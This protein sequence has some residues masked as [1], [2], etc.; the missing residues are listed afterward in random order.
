MDAELKTQLESLLEELSYIC[1]NDFVAHEA[2][3]SIREGI[4]AIFDEAERLTH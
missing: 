1:R 4:L 3:H 2:L